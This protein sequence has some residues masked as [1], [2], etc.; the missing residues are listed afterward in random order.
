M[1]Y[2]TVLYRRK[3]RWMILYF[4]M[5][6]LWRN[7]ARAAFSIY[8]ILPFVWS[9]C[10]SFEIRKIGTFL[11]SWLSISTVDEVYC[12]QMIIEMGKSGVADGLIY[13]WCRTTK[14][15]KTNL[16]WCSSDIFLGW[17]SKNFLKNRKFSFSKFL[18]FS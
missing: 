7:W 16:N 10:A 1:N 5:A 6:I 4:F 14:F 13:S 2:T 17:I 8:K 3:W 9:S 15:F 18:A 11:L 12:L